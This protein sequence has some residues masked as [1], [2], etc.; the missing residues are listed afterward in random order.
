M[1]DRVFDLT[2]DLDAGL[3]A[4]AQAIRDGECV[5]MPTD[6]VYGIAASAFSRKAVKK[7]LEAKQR[8]DDMPPP[9][10]IAEPSMLRAFTA[11][12]PR[13]AVKLADQFWPGAL[14]MILTMQKSL[15]LQ[16]GETGGT[17]AVRVPNHDQARALLRRTGPLAVSSANLHGQDPAT[18]CEQALEALGES[19]AVY[20]DGG[21]TPGLTPSTIVDFTRFNGGQIM[22]E[23]GYG[24]EEL[25]KVALRLRDIVKPEPAELDA[26]EG[27]PALEGPE[28]G[29]EAEAAESAAKESDAAPEESETAQTVE[30]ESAPD[31]E[32]EASSQG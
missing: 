14:T 19:V 20:L 25:K 16:I 12:L 15:Q 29:A 18:T 1:N 9:V 10:L 31:T 17:V 22:R 13:S 23:G 5:V 24:F 6:T 26:P 32:Q 11:N 30:A 21:P 28:S 2:T 3:A 27:Q 7:L 8:G 4:A